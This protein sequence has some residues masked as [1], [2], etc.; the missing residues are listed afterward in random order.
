MD[1]TATVMLLLFLAAVGAMIFFVVR[2]VKPSAPPPDAPAP[3]GFHQRQRMELREFYEAYYLKPGSLIRMKEVEAGLA[4]FAM[5]ARVPAELLRPTDRISDFGERGHGLFSTLLAT[6]L[7]EAI[8]KKPEL[9]GHKL[10]T[11]DDMIQLAYKA[12]AEQPEGEGPLYPVP[13]P[14]E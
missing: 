8:A 3:I 1:L 7:Q 14:I 6:Q 2:L 11:V 10:E 13:P 5:A 12:D 4:M 9:A